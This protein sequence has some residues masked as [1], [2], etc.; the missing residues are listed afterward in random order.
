VKTVDL[1]PLLDGGQWSG[2]QKLLVLATALA[3]V[4]DGVDNQLLSVAIPAIGAEWGIPGSAFAP[5]VAIGLLGMMIG[6]AI[7]GIVGD[8][9]GRRV[10]LLGSVFT[11]GV[12][13]VLLQFVQ[14][15]EALGAVRFLAG[16]GLGGAMPNAA[17]LASE[18]VPRRHRPWAVTLTVVCIPLGGALAGFVGAQI[19]PQLGWRM[20]FAI[21]GA[22]PIV[23][24]VVLLWALPE[25]PRYLARRQARWSEL[26]SLLRRLGHDVP[27]DA[28]FV[29][30]TE[31]PR[32]GTL[33]ELLVPE[34]RRDTVALCASFFF[35]LL[36]AYGGV[37][38][39]PTLLRNAGFDIA[40][41]SNGLLAFNLGGVGGALLGAGVIGRLGSRTTMLGM[42]VI[43]AVS[44]G[45]MA[46]MALVPP[47][48][49]PMFAMF[50]VTGGLINGTQTTM[51]AL[52]AHV[53][54]AAI[55]ATGVGTAVAFGRVGGVLSSYAGSWAIG[56]G[57][58]RFFVM[59]GTM[60]AFVF[61]AL[62]ALVRHIPGAAAAPES[63]AAVGVQP[64]ARRG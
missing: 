64:S 43:A 29:D 2:Y 22:L 40:T 33:G 63:A 5:V 18:Y 26:V 44:C 1:G 27:A 10:A 20:L 42:C 21:G 53:Y 6:G 12:L 59:L 34:F 52:A 45:A 49:V 50:A 35:C 60:M 4:L 23:L 13:T 54:P 7:A 32:Q 28:A 47:A 16:L 36:A 57:G 48:T 3:I 14:S 31:A 24:G 25:S 51:Y 39:L 11:F 38:W 9:F 8:R 41:A 15:V 30:T 17:A 37:F 61:V 19:L 58:A 56:G 62:A 55:R 46:S